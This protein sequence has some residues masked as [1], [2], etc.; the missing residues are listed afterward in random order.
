MPSFI[1]QLG[2]PRQGNWGPAAHT[3]VFNI[4]FHPDMLVAITFDE[5]PVQ[6]YGLVKLQA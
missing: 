6:M 4:N 3:R 5:I 2:C 1:L